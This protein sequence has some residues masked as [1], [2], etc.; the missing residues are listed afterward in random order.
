MSAATPTDTPVR[1]PAE[2]RTDGK[3]MRLVERKGNAA[4][5]RQIGGP[6]TYLEVIR[7]RAVP[8]TV[9]PNGAITP[10][11]EVYPASERFGADAW[12]YSDQS[13][14]VGALAAARARL[15]QLVEPA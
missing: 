14:K 4:I 15:A 13:D 7:I 9:W 6:D 1:L 11:R 12:A 2:L 3:L 8:Q 10:A 5:Y